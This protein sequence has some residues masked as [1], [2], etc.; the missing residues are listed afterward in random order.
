MIDPSP[1][2]GTCVS[3]AYARIGEAPGGIPEWQ[4]AFF[5]T[6]GFEEDLELGSRHFKP[7]LIGGTLQGL[8]TL[9]RGCP[10][11]DR[12]H[13]PIVGKEKSK[14]S[15][16]YPE[17]FCREYGKLAARHFMRIARSEF[18]EARTELVQG[19]L[20]KLQAKKA[21]L[22]EETKA[23]EDRTK[24]IQESV[25]YRKATETSSSSSTSGLVW[26][27]GRGKFGMMQDNPKRA[28]MPA[29]LLHVGGMRDPHKAVLGLPTVQSLGQKI[30]KA[31]EAFVARRPSALEIAETYGTA[32]CKANEEL[33]KEWNSELRRILELTEAPS[34]VLKEKEEY[35]TPIDAELL[36]KWVRISGDREQQLPGG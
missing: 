35:K 2:T 24:E 14:K 5:N 34:V 32:E 3:L 9:R 21:R 19:S 11:G 18:L 22:E 8:Q 33:V 25:E 23:A 16:E 26:K 30:W 13:E 27:E 36:E 4:S 10:C 7:Q 6:C 17:S 1:E 15:A 29:S 28:D 31:W 12:P 20:G